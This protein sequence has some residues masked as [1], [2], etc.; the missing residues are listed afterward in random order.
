MRKQAALVT[1]SS[2]GIGRAIA[3]ELARRG[4]RVAVHG[5]TASDQLERARAECAA[6][7]GAAVAVSGDLGD[8][9]GIEAILDAAETG[10]GPLTTLVSNAG[11]GALR[12]VDL[13]ETQRDSFDHCM[14]LNARAP[15]FLL[16]AFARRL[17]ARPRSQEA[18]YAIISVSSVSAVA[19]SPNRIEYCMSKAAAAM[20]AKAFALRLAPERIQVFDVQPGII[21]TDMSR[22]ALPAYQARIDNEDLLPLPR[23]GHPSDVARTCA[24]AACGDLPYSVGQVLRP[25]GGLLVERL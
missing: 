13:L 20:M 18:H 5:R 21:A 22:A 4:F 1:G 9:D 2:R 7:S 15:F 23:I 10:I 14:A 17:L 16:Q 6:L 11:V 19:A 25:D 3:L 8:L 12:R 24:A